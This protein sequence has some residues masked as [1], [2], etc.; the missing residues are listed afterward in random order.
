MGM[1]AGVDLPVMYLYKHYAHDTLHRNVLRG[2]SDVTAE[3]SSGQRALPK[4]LLQFPP[5]R[6]IAAPLVDQGDEILVASCF[7]QSEYILC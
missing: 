5:S 7:L 3:A 6:D 1:G 4:P 2:F